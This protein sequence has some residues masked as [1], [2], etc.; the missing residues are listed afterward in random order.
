MDL[1]RFNQDCIGKKFWQLVSIQPSDTLQKCIAAT[2]ERGNVKEC[3]IVINTPGN[4]ELRL[5]T[6]IQLANIGKYDDHLLVTM[7]SISHQISSDQPL[8]LESLY[9]QII[10]D[11]LQGI[12]V[13]Q[14]GKYIYVN[15]A[16]AN[17]LE[18][19][20]EELLTFDEKDIWNL[21]HPDDKGKLKDRDKLMD[22]IGTLPM[23]RFRYIAKSGKIKWVESFVKRIVFRG[24]I[25]TQV[26]EIDITD[27][28]LAQQALEESEQQL[29]TVVDSIEDII[30]VYNKNNEYA[31]VFT[32][33]PGIVL[34]DPRELIGKRI[35]ET[36]PKSVA[37]TITKSIDKVRKTGESVTIDYPL[38][39]DGAMHW[40]SAIFSP[41]EDGEHV[42]AV[43][44]DITDRRRIE[45]ALK[46]SQA[47]FIHFA[48]HIPG[49]V[50][51]RDAEGHIFY[52]NRVMRDLTGMDD[53]NGKTLKEL[54]PSKLLKVLTANDAEV[55]EKG[56]ITDTREI[57]LPDK[58]R[59][60]IRMFK[61]RINIPDQTP[62]IGFI[63]IDIS[64][65]IRMEDALRQSE[66]MYRLLFENA[67]VAIIMTDMAGNIVA[68]NKMTLEMFGYT[69]DELRFRNAMNLYV[70]PKERA[71]AIKELR[72][73][74]Q[75]RN[76]ETILRR[77]DGSEMPVLLDEHLLTL[78]NRQLIIS[79]I[80]DIT[81]IKRTTQ[82]LQ[83]SEARYRV[84]FD[85]APVPVLLANTL[86]RL[87]MANS[88]FLNLLGLRE[89]EDIEL[90][91]FCVDFD[92]LMLL[93][94]LL[95]KEDKIENFEMKIQTLRGETLIVHLNI[96]KVTI[97]GE[98]QY[99]A[100]VTDVTD[101]LRN[102]EKIREYSRLLESIYNAIPDAVFSMDTNFVIKTGNS[103][104]EIVFDYSPDE[105]IGLPCNTL[106]ADS[107][108]DL[109]VNYKDEIRIRQD[110]RISEVLFKRR[111]GELFHGSFSIASIRN[112]ENETVG[113]VGL[114]R[115][116]SENI[117]ARRE[118]LATRDRAMLYL[119]LLSHDISNQLQVIL[120]SAQLAETTME[121]VDIT[122]LLTMIE[123]AAIRCTDIIERV[124]S[125]RRMTNIPLQEMDLR[126]RVQFIVEDFIFKF[127]EVKFDVALPNRECSIYADDFIDVLLQNIIEN[128]IIH[129]PY[130]DDEKQVWI[131]L[132]EDVNGYTVR[133]CD[134]GAGVPNERKDKLFDMSQRFGGLG[135]HIAKQIIDKYG[136]RI[137]IKDRVPNRSS[138][139]ASFEIW[140]P[141]TSSRF[142]TTA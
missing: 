10:E 115:D 80:R 95:E 51:I 85:A 18:Y 83:Q 48:E 45:T 57:I 14:N 141:K 30:F 72:K 101:L 131:S 105:L 65:Q 9:R 103:A 1:L 3:N 136:G 38:E 15:Q 54:V 59:R 77:K 32:S 49:M 97:D 29:K 68:A 70:D 41:H 140:F 36:V 52:L 21:V 91:Q 61:F 23:T 119:D 110:F 121:Q 20:I 84:L 106:I 90:S 129:N 88:Q 128:A 50:C 113:Y 107:M 78:G 56:F 47:R 112:Q 135:L 132:I 26:V 28:V 58:S 93:L 39:I 2:K 37:K 79:M 4:N 134:N 75:L 71:K 123:E 102:E 46:E 34:G 100:S 122:S 138:E 31:Q 98:F 43:V 66:Q 74:K 133:I 12:A 69:W 114:I 55:L 17:I 125:T 99:F 67:P 13:I 64:Q 127:T 87:T 27:E 7:G 76:F 104:F 120:G 60:Q 11:S 130:R 111:N 6:Y 124:A 53:W 142:L 33:N 96:S 63:G 86:G 42:I 89:T 126:E 116:E 109:F 117:A 81:N 5:R 22:K 40:F 92:V 8:E 137:T 73:K 62:L 35:D 16:L 24:A 108:K 118:I 82:A 25:A 19:S 94:Q 139:G 44:R